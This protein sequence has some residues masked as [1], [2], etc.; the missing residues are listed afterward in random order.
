MRYVGAHAILTV[1]GDPVEITSMLNLYSKNRPE[2]APCY[3]GSI[4]LNV[5]H[6]E[7][8]AG[9]VGFIKAVLALRHGIVPP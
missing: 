7:A 5:G 6:L 4:K 3:I 9:C 1:V 2:D 8:G